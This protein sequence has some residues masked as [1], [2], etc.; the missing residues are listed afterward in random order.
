MKKYLFKEFIICTALPFCIPYI[1][2]IPD[3]WVVQPVKNILICI[4]LGIDLFFA[5]KYY[6]RF[7]NE[8]LKEVSNKINSE[9]YS[10]ACEICKRK[11]DYII[12]KTY[13]KDCHIPKEWI[14]YDVHNYIAEI[15]NNFCNTIAQITSTDKRY[16]DVTFIYRYKYDSK[17]QDACS[18]KWVS[19]KAATTTVELDKF[20]NQEGTLYNYL[21]NG[22]N[23]EISDSIFCN[24]KIKLE[25]NRHY[26][27]SKRDKAHNKI[28]SVFASKIAFSNNATQF[29]ESIL[30]VSSYGKRFI[31]DKITEY[32]ESELK[33]LIFEELFPYYQKLLETELGMLYLR[34]IKGSK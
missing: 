9:S 31:D 23:G 8:K 27:M 19:G 29:V 1:G 30:V 17:D 28:G 24:D 10:N 21:I 26:H 5:W 13:E 16:M 34:H 7:E 25:E 32:N 4:C 18:W 2:K 12:N 6:K 14:P 20:V 33:N 22:D 11:R 3:T 15:C